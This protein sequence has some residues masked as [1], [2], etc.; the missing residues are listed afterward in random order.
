MRV[1]ST[2][3]VLTENGLTSL[4]EALV[5]RTYGISGM[6]ANL[7]KG[8]AVEVVYGPSRGRRGVIKDIIAVRNDE[9]RRRGEEP[10]LL[11]DVDLVEGPER[12]RVWLLRRI[13]LLDV[14][15]DY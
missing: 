14:L 11:Y 10:Q 5:A 12:F 7:K 9:A 8:D 2:K 4:E 1:D 3:R 6:F 15:A 13:E